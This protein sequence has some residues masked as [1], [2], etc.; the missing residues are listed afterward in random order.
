MEQ[1]QEIHK[2]ME[3]KQDTREKPSGQRGSL[4]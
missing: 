4:T 3:T 1:A 2:H